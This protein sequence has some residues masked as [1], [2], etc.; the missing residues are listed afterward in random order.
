MYAK[1]KLLIANRGEIAVRI[2]R[3]AKELGI[4]TVAIY[5]PS[6]ALS[7]HVTL[8]DE[9]VALP[10]ESDSAESES[11]AYLAASSII[12]ICQQHSIT[13]LHPGYGFLAE[14]HEFAA[15]VLEAGVTWLGPRPEIIKAMG[16]KH[17]ARVMA[18][19]AGVDVV[20]GSEGLVQDEADALA[21][22]NGIGF[23]VIMKA[24]AGGGGMGM[25]ICKDED[26]VKHKFASTKSRAK[27][28]MKHY[29]YCEYLSS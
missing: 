8:A 2:I 28:P 24:T 17:E 27:V 9:A 23:P 21:V 7:P 20:P 15:Q 10:L 16:L 4:R 22:A 6:D 26:E 12:S 11:K 1:Q 19:K 5:T 14:N 13:F 18:I 3:T 25:V 29:F